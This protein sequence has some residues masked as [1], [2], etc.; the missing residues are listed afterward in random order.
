MAN[1]KRQ[2][3]FN[4]KRQVTAS[5]FTLGEADVLGSALVATLPARVVV[6]SVLTNVLTASGTTSANIK[7][8]AGAKTVASNV[9][10]ATAGLKTTNTPQYLPT[11]GD[12]TISA[13]T[14]APATGS[15]QV[16]VIISYIE[17]DKTTGEYTD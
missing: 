8:V 14:T 12:V 6:T 2:G 9:A 10:V 7:V 11:G 17:L 5:I 15:L 3:L 4:Q 16:E 13:G 1:L